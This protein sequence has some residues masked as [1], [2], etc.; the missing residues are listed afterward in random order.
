MRGLNLGIILFIS[1]EVDCVLPNMSY[2]LN[3][4]MVKP[5]STIFRTAVGGHILRTLIII[6]YV[7]DYLSI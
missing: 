6:M 7:N 2:G 1:P 3:I 5:I 4:F